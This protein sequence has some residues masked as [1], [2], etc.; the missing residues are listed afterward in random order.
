MN[1]FKISLEAATQAEYLARIHDEARAQARALRA[2][3][4]DDFWRGANGLLHGTYASTCRSARRLGYALARQR[5][6]RQSGL[7]PLSRPNP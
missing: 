6:R 3:A 5:T 4:I 1:F 7:N 2:Q